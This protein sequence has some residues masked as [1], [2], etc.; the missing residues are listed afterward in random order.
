MLSHTNSI[1]STLGALAGAYRSTPGARFLHAAPMFHLAGSPAAASGR[2]S[3]RSPAGAALLELP[4]R[5]G[6][7]APR[8]L[9]GDAG[10]VD[11]NGYLF[12]V[13]PSRT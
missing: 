2:G 13:E 1:T 4:E 11:D 5:D 3:G 8:R 10:Y 7:S 6:G 12:V 9:T